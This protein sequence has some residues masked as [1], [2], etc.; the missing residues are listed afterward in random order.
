MINR[1]RPHV[2]VLPEDD[3]NRQLANGFLL[4][5]SLS[6]QIQVL[7]EAG[8]WTKVL[9]SFRSDHVRLMISYPDR[10]MIL[11]I[12]FD[13]QEDRLDR[14]RAV[15]PDDLKDRVFV[16]GVWSEPEALKASL[17][18]NNEETGLAMARDCREDTTTTWGHDLLKHNADEIERLR[19]SVRTILFF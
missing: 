13:C 4:H 14:A 2:L 6:T 16:L 17:G 10:I 8:G 19:H 3:A 5:P 9:D 7:E 12:D 18:R 15:I 11:L 1:Y